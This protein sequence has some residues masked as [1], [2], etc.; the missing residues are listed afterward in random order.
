MDDFLMFSRMKART[1]S[2]S[3][4]EEMLWFVRATRRR[5]IVSNASS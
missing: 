3:S 1:P 5:L 2:K 4:G